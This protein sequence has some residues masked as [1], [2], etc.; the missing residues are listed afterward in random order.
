MKSNA[1]SAMIRQRA[2]YYPLDLGKQMPNNVEP[3]ASIVH[4]TRQAVHTFAQDG[5]DLKSVNGE[6]LVWRKTCGNCRSTPGG[7]A[8][9]MTD[10]EFWA[11]F[12]TVC[13]PPRNERTAC[14]GANA[15]SSELS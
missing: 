5:P 3:I 4:P 12:V 9:K 6:Q 10:Q 15:T 2:L 14:R 8:D 11:R 1:Y 7:V 13:L